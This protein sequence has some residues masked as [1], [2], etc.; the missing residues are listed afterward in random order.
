[1]R[2]KRRIAAVSG[3]TIQ[4]ATDMRSAAVAPA[5]PLV[6]RKNASDA[7]PNAAVPSVARSVPVRMASIGFTRTDT[8]RRR[9]A[10]PDGSSEARP[11]TVTSKSTT[12]ANQTTRATASA[13]VRF[14][15]IAPAPMNE[16]SATKIVVSATA[17]ATSR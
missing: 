2:R 3:A 6:K 8:M 13:R 7:D 16:A 4:N 5:L 10:R 17:L 15:P 9:D 12:I 1:M 14:R 11:R